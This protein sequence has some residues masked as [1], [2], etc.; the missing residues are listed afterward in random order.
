MKSVSL[1]VVLVLAQQSH[2]ANLNPCRRLFGV[3]RA[4]FGHSSAGIDTHAGQ[5]TALGFRRIEDTNL[6][7]RAE[8]TIEVREG[9]APR[10]WPNLTDSQLKHVLHIGRDQ[11]GQLIVEIYDGRSFIRREFSPTGSS[12]GQGGPSKRV[13]ADPTPLATQLP[14]AGFRQTGPKLFSLQLSQSLTVAAVL[15]EKG[16]LQALVKSDTQTSPLLTDPNLRVVGYKMLDSEVR[17]VLPPRSVVSVES[18]LAKATVDAEGRILSTEANGGD[19]RTLTDDQLKIHPFTPAKDSA[20]AFVIGGVNSDDV[21]AG[22]TSLNGVSIA[23]LEHAMRPDQ[24]STD[25]FLGADES[26]IGVLLADNAFVRQAGLTHQTIAHELKRMK[27]LAGLGFTKFKYRGR[28]FE[29]HLSSSKGWQD[30]PFRDG[31]AH[32]G[33][34]KLTNLDTGV[35]TGGG[36]LVLDLIERYG[37][38]EGQGTRYRVDP[39]Q[40]VRVLDFL[41]PPR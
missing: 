4:A 8:M 20:S 37:F 19:L 28:H 7:R 41:T 38:Y 23:E 2:A 17:G 36:Q 11:R 22:L 32:P 40:L 16:Q 12:G 13:P 31:T 10:L 9:Q 5:L 39:R 27:A 34:F 14:A 15:N 3:V 24:S 29:L 30:S 26:L 1:V 21:I 25:G 33:D 6:Y 18:V 35:S